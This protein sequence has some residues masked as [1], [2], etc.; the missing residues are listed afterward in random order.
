MQ[1]GVKYDAKGKIT[2]LYDLSNNENDVIQTDTSKSFTF[3]YNGMTLD[4]NRIMQ[5]TFVSEIAQP[6]IFSI[7][8]D[9]SNVLNTYLCDG[10]S[11]TKRHA[12]FG[13]TA[14]SLYAGT[15]YNSAVV[16]Y[17]PML[18]TVRWDT[19]DSIFVNNSYQA[20]HDAGSQSLT[21]MM[22][23]GFYDRLLS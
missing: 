18:L 1:F 23:G 7:V 17:N 8:T 4:G 19:T 11:S 21:G 12:I 20:S 9:K 22:L 16:S 6:N 13:S 15:L 3:N 14:I 10:I 5:S 2:K